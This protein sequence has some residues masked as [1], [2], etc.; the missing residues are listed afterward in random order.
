M[1]YVLHGENELESAE[2]L[3][4]VI[5]GTGIEADFKDLNTEILEAPLSIGELRRACGTIP[6][7]GDTRIVIAQN[8]LNKADK[9]TIKAITDYLADL[10]PTTC[11]IFTEAKTLSQKQKSHAIVCKT[12]SLSE[13]R[14]G[15]R[16]SD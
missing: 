3:A 12:K 5:Q 11:L 2:A 16:S 14:K 8:T 4:K 15:R 13:T 7:L 1:L 6:F 9:Q 10:P